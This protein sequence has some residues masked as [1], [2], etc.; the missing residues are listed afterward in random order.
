MTLFVWNAIFFFLPP[1]TRSFI[2]HDRSWR[3]YM[4]K[5]YKDDYQYRNIEPDHLH[6]PSILD[7]VN[8]R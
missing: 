8:D 6:F 1:G 2:F 4:Q 3:Q 5:I 7:Y